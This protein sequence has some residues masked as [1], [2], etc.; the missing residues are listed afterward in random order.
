VS[1]S[2]FALLVAASMCRS[3]FAQTLPRNSADGD[4]VPTG[5]ASGAPGA[6]TAAG[7]PAGDKPAG[8]KP[9]GDKPAPNKAAAEKPDTPPAGVATPPDYVIGP[10][11]LLTIIFW[12][13]KDLSGDVLVRPDG[14]ISLP[15]LN[16]VQAA[17]LTPEQLREKLV[18]AA[19]DFL[20][21]ANAT[22]V[23]KEVRSRQVFIT[24]QVAKPGPY[25]LSGPT[26]VV[27][28][29]S[30]AGGLTDYADKQNIV[31]LHAERRPDGEP[32]SSRVNY[33]DLM[34]RKNIRQNIE[35]KPGDTVVVP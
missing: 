10:N 34:K 12:R 19:G 14:M 35:L 33:S 21:E 3:A 1:L 25:P 29:I 20:E 9:A 17:G 5:K 31:I 23:V 24:G 22:V 18:A 11:D 28:L 27:Q 16:D 15:L 6:G 26:T 13:E 7:K 4:T 2:L 8:D 30:M 32:L